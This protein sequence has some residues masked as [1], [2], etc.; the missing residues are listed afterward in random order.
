[1]ED[2]EVRIIPGGA[3]IGGVEGAAWG[4]RGDDSIEE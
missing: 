2:G 3:K 4:W 1:M